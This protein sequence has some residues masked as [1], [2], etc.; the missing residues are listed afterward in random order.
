MCW[1]TR[2]SDQVVE[3]KNTF[4][5]NRNWN[6]IFPPLFPPSL[7]ARHSIRFAAWL[8]PLLMALFQFTYYARN[9]TIWKLCVWFGQCCAEI[10]IIMYVCIY[11]S[12]PNLKSFIRVHRS[13]ITLYGFCLCNV[14]C[15]CAMALIR[16]YDHVALYYMRTFITITRVLEFVN[17]ILS[18]SSTSQLVA[19]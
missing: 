7:S 16:F 8:R 4:T 18:P 17:E 3:R 5:E 19:I 9:N 14:L 2:T 10:F 12:L 15:V 6:A 1:C 11:R 13:R